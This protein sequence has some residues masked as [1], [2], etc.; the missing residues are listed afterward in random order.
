LLQTDTENNLKFYGTKQITKHLTSTQFKPINMYLYMHDISISQVILMKTI[1][2][3]L[4][5]FL[6]ACTTPIVVPNDPIEIDEQVGEIKKF[7][8]AQSRTQESIEF[9]HLLL[10][11]LSIYHLLQTSLMDTPQFLFLILCLLLLQD[12]RLQSQ[13]H[14]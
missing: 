7:N 3:T 4:M 6:V 14:R 9:R 12:K 8:S 2:L 11:K 5:I 13:D 1:I 10:K